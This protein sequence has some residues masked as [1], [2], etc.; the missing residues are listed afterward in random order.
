MDI[1]SSDEEILK[2]FNQEEGKKIQV[3]EQLM[4]AEK[5]QALRLL[6]TWRDRFCSDVRKLP[7]TDLIEHRIPTIK[8]RPVRMKPKLYT[9]KEVEWQK[10][11]LPA[12]LDAGIIDWVNS[13]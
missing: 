5:S 2:W 12:L 1:A 7:A 3:G 9:Q 6:Y 8:C 13:P 4:E 11:H 10:E